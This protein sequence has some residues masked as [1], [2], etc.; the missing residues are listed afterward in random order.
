MNTAVHS[1]HNQACPKNKYF[2]HFLYNSIQVTY[3][4]SIK[5]PFPKGDDQTKLSYHSQGAVLDPLDF[6][7]NLLEGQF[8]WTDLMSH[9]TC[10]MPGFTPI[11]RHT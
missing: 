6:L 7:A 3:D 2:Q 9:I 5:R 11:Q 8:T 4:S 1:I 10:K